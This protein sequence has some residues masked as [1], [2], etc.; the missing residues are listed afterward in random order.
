MMQFFWQDKN[1]NNETF[2]PAWRTFLLFQSP[3]RISI[4]CSASQAVTHQL[5]LIQQIGQTGTGRG[6][7]RMI[8]G[9]WILAVPISAC[10]FIVG[11]HFSFISPTHCGE[12]AVAAALCWSQEDGGWVG[13][14]KGR[15][16]KMGKKGRVHKVHGTASV[17]K[18]CEGSHLPLQLQLSNTT[19]HWQVNSG[20]KKSWCYSCPPYSTSA[21][22]IAI[23]EKFKI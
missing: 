7:L 16:G 12:M 11:K 5:L 18:R 19:L 3:V 22:Y 6:E 20:L 21:H 14:R 10:S 17:G 1:H 8:M 23:W 13:E 9:L 4:L 2:Q 15:M